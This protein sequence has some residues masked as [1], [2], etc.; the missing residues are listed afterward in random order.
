M[1]LDPFTAIA[2]SALIGGVSSALGNAT[3]ANAANKAAE[4][5]AE[6]RAENTA[7]LQPYMTAGT[8]A[9]STYMNALGL[10]GG[11]AQNGY[12]SGVGN[13]N[14]N[15]G[16]Q[17]ELSAGNTS[18]MKNAAALGLGGAQANTLYNIGN[19]SGNLANTFQQQQLNEIAGVSNQGQQAGQ[20][21]T[22]ANTVGAN[23][24]AGNMVTAGNYQGGIYNG[25]GQASNQ[26][27]QNY[28]NYSA[29]LAGQG[30][31]NL[32]TDDYA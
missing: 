7:N 18:I 24:Q 1:G 19:Y 22:G 27:V 17:A 2:G 9:L 32:G 25:L 23:N 20:A 12:Y 16:Y 30:G 6:T 8:G 4:V 14:N 3:A 28:L 15:P 11:A 10:N 29:R 13:V 5:Q 31:N 26:G 21:L